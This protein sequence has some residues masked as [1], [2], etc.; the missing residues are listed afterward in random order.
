VKPITK[1]N[2][3]ITVKFFLNIVYQFGVPNT[4]ITDNGTNFVGKKLL[5][6]V[7][8]YGIRI[9]WASVGHQHTNGQSERADRMVLQEL[10]HRIFDQLK[11]FAGRWVQEL[12]AVLWSLRTT[13]NRSMEFTPFF[14]AYGAEA[15]L[16]SNLDYGAPRVKAF[17][18]DQAAEA[19]QDAVDL[20]EEARETA[21][22]HS[23]RYQ[24]TLRRYHKRKI[25]RR[26][27]E[28]GDLVLRRAQST[29]DKHKLTPPWEGPY[30]IVEVVRL[31]TY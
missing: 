21:L 9:D 14:L 26:T 10:K 20:L 29:K 15:V 6:F 31:G 23:A 25:W 16:P 12:P 3:Q 7:D 11:K 4:I 1:T 19:Q 2:S 24:Q 18:P 5:E 22:V 27:L 17:D 28:V 8:R 30:T 13:P